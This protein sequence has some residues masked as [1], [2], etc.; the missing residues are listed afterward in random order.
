MKTFPLFVLLIAGAAAAQTAEEKAAT[1]KWLA[2]CRNADGGY[3]LAPG[4]K[5][6]VGATSAAIRALK[7]CGAGIPD[8]DAVRKYLLSCR[9]TDG[10]FT[11]EPG[12][13]ANCLTTS[14][15]IMGLAELLGRDH[16]DVKLHGPAAVKWL[17][18]NVRTF[19]DARIA[20]AA[21]ETLGAKTDKAEAWIALLGGPNPD[22]EDAAARARRIGGAVAGVLR[23]APSHQAKDTA[24]Q[25]I[26][27]AQHTDGGWARDANSGPDLETTY[28]VMRTLHMTKTAPKDAAAA[29]AF[30]AKCRNPDGGYGVQP[31]KPSAVN[32]TYYALTVLGW[33]P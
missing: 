27:D 29:R 12:G 33:L 18:D 13:P 15:G 9:T 16:A 21:L 3:A 7:K 19:E 28:R 1:A 23:L 25:A 8:S 2:T 26:T 30:V 5:S 17:E 31:G 32:G 6:S 4:G 22:A 11:G 20:A 14:V 10:G 24:I